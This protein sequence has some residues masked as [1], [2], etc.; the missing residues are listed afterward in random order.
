[1]RP[2]GKVQTVSP[3][4]EKLSHPCASPL[5]QVIHKQKQK[6]RSEETLSYYMYVILLIKVFLEQQYQAI[7][8]MLYNYACDRDLNSE[9]ARDRSLNTSQTVQPQQKCFHSAQQKPNAIESLISFNEEILLKMEVF[10]TKF[11]LFQNK[12]LLIKL[13]GIKKVL[14]QEM[15]TQ[16]VSV[17]N[18][19]LNQKTDRICY[20]QRRI[21]KLDPNRNRC[22]ECLFINFF[23]GGGSLYVVMQVQNYTS[24]CDHKN[25]INFKEWSPY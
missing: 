25:V 4:M 14:H 23:L 11:I 3:I 19:V 5:N 9:Y 17:A 8:I 13:L 1:M 20:S 22:H 24:L 18:I 15:E 2:H 16:Q 6:F 21:L 7:I 10:I 12:L